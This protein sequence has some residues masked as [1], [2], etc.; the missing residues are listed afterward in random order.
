MR[1]PEKTTTTAPDIAKAP[2]SR[3]CVI[4]VFESSREQAL[5]E[6]AALS[7]PDAQG[8][9]VEARR[10]AHPVASGELACLALVEWREHSGRTGGSSER[11][12]TANRHGTRDDEGRDVHA[13]SARLAQSE[14]IPAD[15]D[16]EQC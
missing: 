14:D 12:E 10:R 6:P 1:Y 9:D 11:H 8:G 16:L 3:S 5:H 13:E 2:L 4:G 7:D 15:T